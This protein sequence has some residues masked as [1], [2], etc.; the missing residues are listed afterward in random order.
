METARGSLKVVAALP[1]YN[2]AP[3]IAEV[4][5]KAKRHVDQVVVVDDGSSD[6]T[7]T[8]AKGAGA[9]L[10]NHGANKGYGEAI[11]S[12]FRA[13]AANNADILVILDGDGQHNP[14]EIPNLLGPILRGEADLTIGSRF[15]KGCITMPAYRRF[16]ISVINFLWNFGSRVRVSDTQSGFRA[17]SRR[18]LNGTPYS[19]KGMSIS[20]E[21]LEKARK[22]GA[23]IR[24]VES[25]CLYISSPL[26]LKAVEHGLGVALSVIRIRA[27]NDLFGSAR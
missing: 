8:A 26:N 1:C 17:Y 22:I 4:V 14:E 13:G 24:E 7:A 10:V 20:I 16:G 9:S 2:V 3:Y 12:C 15:I 5:L 25:S 21:I 23:T 19:E 6:G 18:L 27:R 11:K